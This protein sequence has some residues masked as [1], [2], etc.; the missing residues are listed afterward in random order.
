M[1]SWKLIPKI[2]IESSKYQIRFGMSISEVQD[3][4]GSD[5]VQLTSNIA[6]TGCKMR[7]EYNQIQELEIIEFFEGS[8]LSEDTEI[9]N[10]TITKLSKTLLKKEY[11]LFYPSSH[12]LGQICP[13]LCIGVMSSHDSGGTSKKIRCITIFNSDEQLNFAFS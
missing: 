13:Q 10:T 3:I 12:D 6:E 4:I 11:E 7:F 2:G 5:C 8:L 1:T 9:F